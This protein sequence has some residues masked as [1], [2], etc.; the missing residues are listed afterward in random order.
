LKA[1]RKERKRKTFSFIFSL[2][3]ETRKQEVKNIVIF[4]F[5][6]NGKIGS[7][8]F[9]T[10][11]LRCETGNFEAKNLVIFVIFRLEAKPGKLEAKI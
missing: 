11:L 7:K 8:I 6:A 1:K 4:R 10:F 2:S 9:I 5:Q 3:S